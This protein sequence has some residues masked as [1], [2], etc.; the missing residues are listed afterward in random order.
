VTYQSSKVPGRRAARLTFLSVGLALLALGLLIVAGVLSRDGEPAGPTA[1]LPVSVEP[2]PPAYPIILAALA[3]C[4][5]VMVGSAAAQTTAA[6]RVLD[7]ARRPPRV[8]SAEARR[9]ASRLLGPSAVARYELDRDTTLPP[10][11]I[12]PPPPASRVQLTVL[13][14]AHNEEL[15]VATALSSLWNQS[16]RPDR[17]IVVADNCTDA[18]ADIARASGAEVFATRNNAEKKAGALNQVLATVLPDSSVHDVI[19]VMDADSVVTPE[20]LATA[21]GRLEADPDLIAVGGVFAG[22][23][24]GGLIGQLQRN[25][26]SRYQRHIS[27]RRGKVFVL[28]GTA[29]VFRG[30]ALNAVAESRGTLIPGTHGQVYDTLALTEDNELTL[31]L[32]TL[33]AR[34]VSPRECQVITEI[35]PNSRALWRQRSRWQR[36]ALENIGVY[37]LTRTTARY[38]FQ[39]VGIGYGTVALSAYLLLILITLLAADAYEPS[40]FWICIGVIFIVERIVTVAAQGWRGVLLAAPLVLELGYS[41]I[42]QAVY[43]GSLIDIASGRK[44]EW[45]TVVR[46]ATTQ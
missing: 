24:G 34:M 14:P 22:E 44:P 35:M 23:D 8:S 19:M 41:L 12:P 42:L 16:R 21:L 11:A 5:A 32:K 3:A 20:F 9:R 29:S 13:V 38:W 10:S 46:E 25:E 43:I 4:A 17:V 28:T 36:G 27:R 37:G 26:Y 40:V 45:N 31:A 39:Q 7:P 33:G 18:T 1:S 2:F 15:T 6:M 30:Y